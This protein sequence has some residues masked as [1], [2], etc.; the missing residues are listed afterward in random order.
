MKK[1]YKILIG[2][3]IS[4]LFLI[5][6][7]FLTR[8]NNIYY[9]SLGDSLSK[10]E[11]S[12]S[13][14]KYGYSSYV[15]D[16]LNDKKILKRYVN[17]FSSKNYR[18]IDI[19]NDIINNKKIV[20]NK[21]TISLK[22]ALIKAD[23]VTLSIGMND[24]FYKLNVASSFEI[25][26]LDDIYLY[27][28]EAMVDIDKLLYELRRNCKEQIIVLGYYNPFI[29]YDKSLSITVEPYILYANNK[30][31]SLICKYDMTYIDLHEL[32]LAH[33]EYLP[34]KYDYRPKQ[35]GYILIGK[36]VLENINI[37]NY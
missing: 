15:K 35:K 18:S 33:S 27:I 9:L 8:D 24:I 16:Y 3:I 21:K 10:G 5:V 12:D 7:F 4:G 20:D 28:D 2:F 26:N 19:Y 25:N 22:N 31:K 23:I 37:I 32:F 13:F 14:I 29:N 30:L 36:K 6:I 11:A 1:R 17:G 34:E